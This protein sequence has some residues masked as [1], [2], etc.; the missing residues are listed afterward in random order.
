MVSVGVVV[1]VTGA[2]VAV[3]APAVVLVVSAVSST[4]LPVVMEPGV[5]LVV[6]AA[7]LVIGVLVVMISPSGTA[8]VFALPVSKGYCRQYKKSNKFLITVTKIRR[9]W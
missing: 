6:G 1:V 3:V 8:V 7:V 9:K 5:V 2:G 4:G